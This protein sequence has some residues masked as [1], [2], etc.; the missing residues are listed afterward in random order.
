MGNPTNPA[1]LLQVTGLTT[2]FTT[3][4][5][6]IHAVDNVSFSVDAGKVL[7]IVG[8]SGSGKS[9]AMRSLMQLIRPPGKV[10]GGTALYRGRDLL[11]LSNKEI[12][13]LR[14]DKI[15]MI[16]QN[17]LTALN[18]AITIGDQ[19]AE[20]LILHRGMNRKTARPLVID[21]LKKVGISAAERRIDDYPAQ[22]SGGMC[23]RILIA[24][25]LSCQPDI[26]IADE[27]TTA[28][29]VSIQAQILELLKELQSEINNALILITHDLGVV[30]SIA[31]E[32]M[33]MYAG[34]TIEQGPV[35]QM[36]AAPRHPYTQ[37]LIDSAEAL[38]DPKR[39]IR[40]IPGV[41]VVPIGDRRGCSFA[42]RCNFSDG[43]RCISQTPSLEKL[44]ADHAVACHVKP[45]RKASNA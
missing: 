14:G 34:Q 7:C 40:P 2:Q 23:Q 21:L 6:V 5:G 43:T 4:R 42:P 38:E 31:D 32:V 29:D 22:F 30:A 26:L 45:T 27:P 35:E 9:V 33:V 37:G 12:A 10:V 36:F 25:A 11:A 16:F 39:A 3:P 17:P 24:T 13:E 18:P 19:I 1:K 28:L 8:E 41:P 20:S 44:T 15:S